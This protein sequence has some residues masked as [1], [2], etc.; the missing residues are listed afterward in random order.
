MES[1]RKRILHVFGNEFKILRNDKKALVYFL[2]GPIIVIGMFGLATTTIGGSGLG[3]LA[4]LKVA[5][6]DEDNS[7]LSQSL[8]S[9]F[10][11]ST[12]MD[13][14]Y[15]TD[16]VAAMNNFQ[17]GKVDIVFIIE[18]GFE[19]KLRSFYLHPS[20]SEKAILDIVVDT[21]Y[22]TP[23]SA[24]QAIANEVLLDFFMRDALPRILN[25]PAG[26][27]IPRERIE[28]LIV[29]LS[30]INPRLQTPYGENPLFAILF[31]ILTPLI[32][33]SFSIQLCGLSIVGERIRGTLSRIL[34]TP[35]RRS[36][37]VLGKLLAYLA[38]AMTQ[39]LGVLILTQ[40]F[41]LV[42][43]SGLI[44]LFLALLL[45]SYAGCALGIFY[46]TF[47][48]SEKAVI[49]MSN[50]TVLFLNVAGGAI[51][52]LSSMPEIAQALGELLPTSH[53]IS[54]FRYITVKG[55]GPESWLLELGYLALFG[56]IVVVLATIAFK[57]AKAE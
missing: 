12:R 56:T 9:R 6:V 1:K 29:K 55:L 27:Q 21:S 16:R 45:T 26:Q 57:F 38:I 17:R 35:V 39:S 53:S 50:L 20:E 25:L 19:G 36:E 14:K 33:M 51:F 24:A 44:P 10:R 11:Q 22:V 5:V 34:K 28:E 32:L 37:I 47:S 15:V 52:P 48:T 54:A 30:P 49:Q 2:L 40:F 7:P 42:V 46:S 41:G 4:V 23:P 3:G 8:V 31:P 43:K 18:K 13:V